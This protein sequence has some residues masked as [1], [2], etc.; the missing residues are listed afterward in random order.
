MIASFSIINIM[1]TVLIVESPAKGK[2]IQSFFKDGTI[3]IASL[4]HIRD[5][6]KKCLSID[7]DRDF[8]P[9]YV[10]TPDKQKTI[11]RIQNY[12]KSCEIILAADDD[13]EG[14]A[15]AWHC[16]QVANLDFTQNNRIIFHEISKSA[17]KKA[18]DNIHPINMN[19]VNAQQARRVI[20]RLVGFSLSPLLWNHIQTN[21]KGLSA[22]RVQS[23]LLSMLKD[24]EDK[25][26]DFKGS[27]D[28]SCKGDF[29]FKDTNTDISGSSEGVFYPIETYEPQQ[30]LKTFS[31]NREFRIAHQGHKDEKKYPPKPLITSTLQ[32]CSQKELRFSIKK[33]MTI[34]RKLYENGKITYMRTD[35]SAISPEFQGQLCNHIKETWSSEYYQPSTTGKKVKGAQEAHECIRVTNLE[36]RLNDRYSDEDRKLYA[37]IKRYTII[38]HMKSAIYDVLTI[39]LTTEESSDM[40]TFQITNKVLTF[41]GFLIYYDG[42]E[43]EYQL[44]E[45]IKIHPDT[46]FEL[47]TSR[48]LYEPE[49]PPTYYDESSI[50]RKLESSGVGRPS[51]YA[52]IIGTVYSRNYTE[53][54]TIPPVEYE[55][56]S[57]TLRKGNEIVSTKDIV[58]TR[59][60]K[61]KIILTDLGKQVLVYLLAHFSHILNI[62][63]TSQVEADLDRINNGEI[64]WPRVV[65]KVYD[66]FITEVTVQK[67]L[68][69]QKYQSNRTNQNR[70]LGE[71]NGNPVILKVGPYGPYLSYNGASK[72]LKYFLQTSDKS[73]EELV[74]Y[75]IIDIIRYPMNVGKHRGKDVIIQI[76]RHGKYM[77]YDK[78]N[79]RIPQKDDY[80]LEECISLIK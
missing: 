9:T 24:H 15:I 75:D 14:D 51:T 3:C 66:S 33:T 74:L 69:P 10:E 60:Q 17:I 35:S 46:T 40:G 6:D 50:V 16:G 64:E 53:V 21:Q 77:K 26:T 11:H 32:Q 22:G 57:V 34:A 41:K 23:T 70:E 38:S 78:K 73:V 47:Q 12:A 39:T 79:H 1:K 56:E 80:S 71:Y 25:I 72:T 37:L 62:S 42:T 43:K 31:E 45:Q 55:T 20:D 4:G 68:K 61:Q 63:F 44:A 28:L 48:C 30:L 7:V 59:P 49:K 27:T 67:S 29:T 36:E 19:S 76:G 2:K 18:L 58:K 8:E 52:S 65:K 13:R 54:K 5:L